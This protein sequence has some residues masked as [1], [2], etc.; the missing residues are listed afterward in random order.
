MTDDEME[1]TRKRLHRYVPLLLRMKEE[2]RQRVLADQGDEVAGEPG[3]Y[4]DP[5]S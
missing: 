5:D 3:A 1:E 4:A 2:Q